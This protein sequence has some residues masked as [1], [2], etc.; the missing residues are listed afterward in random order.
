MFTITTRTNATPPSAQKM[1]RQ[2]SSCPTNPDIAVPYV[3]RETRERPERD[4]RETRERPERLPPITGP[5]T[6]P[7]S[8]VTEYSP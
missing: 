6:V 4:Q 7:N 8:T 2:P 1:V 3:Q 5:K